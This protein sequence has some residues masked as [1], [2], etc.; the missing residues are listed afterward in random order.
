LVGL[1]S[2]RR[3]RDLPRTCEP[4]RTAAAADHDFWAEA[5]ESLIGHAQAGS[6]RAD[7]A[8]RSQLTEQT[9]HRAMAARYRG[10][11]PDPE[12]TAWTD[13]GWLDRLLEDWQD[14]RRH[15]TSWPDGTPLPPPPAPEPPLQLPGVPPPLTMAAR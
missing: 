2:H 14:R 3:G 11:Y 15:H 5:G 10:Q 13:A 12:S 6:I 8:Q 9:H 4:C 1:R 7:P